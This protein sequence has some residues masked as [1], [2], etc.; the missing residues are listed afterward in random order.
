MLTNIL[1]HDRGSSMRKHDNT[2]NE[3]PFPEMIRTLPEADIPLKGARA[4][5]LQTE[6]RQVVFFDVPPN[7]EIPPHSHG[8]Q[9]GIVVEGEVRMIIGDKTKIYRKGDWYFIP[10]G[11]VHS[12]TTLTKGNAIEIVDDPKRYRAKKNKLKSARQRK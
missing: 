7:C 6:S 2:Q 5:L 9:W 12:A 3:D 1:E 10:K 8:D 11:V 4:W